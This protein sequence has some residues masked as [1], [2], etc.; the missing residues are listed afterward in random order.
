[1]VLDV[2]VNATADLTPLLFAGALYLLSKVFRYG[3]E[4]QTLFDETL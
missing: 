2:T 4:L 3:Q 1:M